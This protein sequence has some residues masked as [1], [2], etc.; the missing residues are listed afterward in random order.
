MKFNTAV[1]SENTAVMSGEHRCLLKEH[2]SDLGRI[3]LSSPRTPQ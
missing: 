3:L 1:L 2:R